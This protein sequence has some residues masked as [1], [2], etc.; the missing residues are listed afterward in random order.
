MYVILI[1]VQSIV[2]SLH[3]TALHPHFEALDTVLILE[4]K[5]N[6]I[7]FFFECIT[8]NFRDF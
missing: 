3:S 5:N 7:S 4:E 6:K 8:Y 2:A 1:P